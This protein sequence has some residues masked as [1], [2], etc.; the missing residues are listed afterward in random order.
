MPA[1]TLPST[2]CLER[3]VLGCIV[4]T[5][6]FGLGG[7]RSGG[8]TYTLGYIFSGGV[9]VSGGNTLRGGGGV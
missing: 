9:Q 1:G 3:G 8:T 7:G 5:S 6:L 4:S 2:L